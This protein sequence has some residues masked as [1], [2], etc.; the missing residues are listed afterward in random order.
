VVIAVPSVVVED[1]G[2]G[3]AGR[4]VVLEQQESPLGKG[5]RDAASAD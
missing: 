1:A 4:A 3:A 5:F 2:C